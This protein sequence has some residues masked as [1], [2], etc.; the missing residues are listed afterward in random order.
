MVIPN[1]FFPEMTAFALPLHGLREELVELAAAWADEHSLFVALERFFPTYAAIALPQGADVAAA[2]GELEPVRRL[3]LRRGPF[4]EGAINERQHL[5][6]NPEC[7]TIVLE[8]VTE[9][10]LRATAI[11]SR[12][13]DEQR[14]REW[15]ALVREAAL[16]MHRGAHAIEPEHG[17]RQHVPEHFHTQGAHDLAAGG[18]RM[19]AAAGTAI[20]EFEDLT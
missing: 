15:V 11:S 19:L 9:D 4:F 8:P 1:P 10:G 16:R 5:A 17:G 18:V 7:L 20:F 14:L 13:G 12:M 2:I 6:R 3:C